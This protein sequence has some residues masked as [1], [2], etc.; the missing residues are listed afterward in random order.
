MTLLGLNVTK[1]F[2]ASCLMVQPEPTPAPSVRPSMGPTL[3]SVASII[4]N[5][6]PSLVPTRFLSFRPSSRTSEA[7][8]LITTEKRSKADGVNDITII[9]LLVVV[10]GSIVLMGY[11]CTT[12]ESANYS[13]NWNS[14]QS[15]VHSHP[16]QPPIQRVVIHPT[17]KSLMSWA[18]KIKVV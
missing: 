12:T 3:L 4:P 11:L 18:P 2:A 10:A 8:S 9:A 7:P 14:S 15:G 5:H 6:F 17:N 1:A 13:V 16:N